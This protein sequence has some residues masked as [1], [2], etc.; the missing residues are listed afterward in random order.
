MQWFSKKGNTVH[1]ASLFLCLWDQMYQFRVCTFWLGLGSRWNRFS[2]VLLLMF[3][4]WRTC[5]CTP[6]YG[7]TVLYLRWLHMAEPP[8]TKK[9]LLNFSFLLLVSFTF[10]IGRSYSASC[11]DFGI[12]HNMLLKL[13]FLDQLL[14]FHNF[15]NQLTD[16]YECNSSL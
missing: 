16:F 15:T 13:L 8:A 10:V 3:F 11:M 12:C 2:S 14:P 9:I 6:G 7:P 1:I 5:L 4:R